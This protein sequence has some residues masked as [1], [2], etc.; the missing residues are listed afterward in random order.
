MK[1]LS[2]PRLSS[3]ALTA[4]LQFV[5]AALLATATITAGAYWVVTRNAVAEATR[6]AQEIAAI[7]GRGIVQPGLTPGVL[8]GDPA[9]TAAFDRLIRDRVLG[10]RVVRVKLWTASGS[11]VYSDAGN[12]RG[13]SFGLDS[14]RST[15]LREN[16][17]V[18]EVTQ[19]DQPENV[20]ERGF[21]R[22]LEAYL[23]IRAPDGRTL[24]FETYQ[25]YSSIDD[26][27]RRIWGSFFPV[28]GGG[29]LLLFAVQVPLAWR[30]ARSLDIAQREREAMLKRSLEASEAERRR[31]ARDLH[32]GV[33]QTLAGVALNLSALAGQTNGGHDDGVGSALRDAAR[34]T[35]GAVGDLRSL[36]VEIAPPNLEGARLEGALADLLAPLTAEG[37]STSLHAEGLEALDRDTAALLY[38]AALESI[39]NAS[40][41]AGAGHVDVEVSVIDGAIR[42]EV[43]D[44]GRGFTADEVIE[45]QRGGHVGLAMLRSLV[46]DSGGSLGIVSEPGAGSRILVELG[47][48]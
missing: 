39:R 47:A 42:L 11:I 45:R 32:D 9:A 36:I 19:L 22:L 44:D 28:L 16:R 48:S 7:D 31:I 1:L 27:Q 43:R 41:H 21:G 29:I 24:L 6:N 25:V 17:V 33:V 2:L 12:L 23:P 10:N 37:L 35:R 13:K 38:R 26:D 4:V 34:S 46:E 15:A 3:P 30:M 5:F 18:A 14:A 20:S 8:T 40:A